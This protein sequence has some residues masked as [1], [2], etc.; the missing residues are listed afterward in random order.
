MGKACEH[1]VGYVCEVRF[2]C[3]FPAE[4][5]TRGQDTGSADCDH[6]IWIFQTKWLGRP[7]YKPA[8]LS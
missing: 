5:G 7:E 2:V 6:V 3:D 4:G 1:A 8:L